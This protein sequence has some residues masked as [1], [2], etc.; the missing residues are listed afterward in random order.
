MARPKKAENQPETAITA[1]PAQESKAQVVLRVP[2]E[3]AVIV[4]GLVMRQKGVRVGTPASMSGEGGITWSVSEGYDREIQLSKETNQNAASEARAQIR[5]NQ[6]D[7]NQAMARRAIMARQ[8][9]E[10]PSDGLAASI[11]EEDARI[12][13]LKSKRADLEA[14]AASYTAESWTLPYLLEG[15]R[16]E[17]E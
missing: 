15:V 8:H 7:I 11:A 5:R 6:S 12:E 2:H 4:L 17:V 16:I 13:E 10:K 3:A 1:A 9:E 14:R